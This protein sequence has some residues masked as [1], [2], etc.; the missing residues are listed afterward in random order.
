MRTLQEITDMCEEL[1]QVDRDLTWKIEVA[2]TLKEA[3][4]LA[5]KR[6]LN[7]QKLNALLWV[8]SVD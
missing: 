7:K 1:K 5:L 4:E 3:N 8:R 6:M 2:S